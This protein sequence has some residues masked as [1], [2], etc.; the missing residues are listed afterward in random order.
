MNHYTHNAGPKRFE[1]FQIRSLRTSIASPLF[2]VI[3]RAKRDTLWETR[4]KVTASASAAWFT[5]LLRIN[6]VQVFKWKVKVNA[7]IKVAFDVVS[8]VGMVKDYRL[9]SVSS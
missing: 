3:E 1:M 8:R 2:S 6:L 9:G 7:P 4:L 5:G